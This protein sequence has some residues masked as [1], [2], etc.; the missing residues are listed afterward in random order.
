MHFYAVIDTNVIVSALFKPDSVPGK[1]LNHALN[2]KIIPLFHEIIFAEYYDVIKRPKFK[3]SQERIDRILKSVIERGKFIDAK[4]YDEEMPDPKDKI[5]YWVTLTAREEVEAYLVTGNLKH[6]PIK[7]FIVT[8]R[9][10][11]EI[12]GEED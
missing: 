5:F 4:E 7:P 8:P 6:F 11:L 9:E 10:M 3:F 2:G 1:I 12:L